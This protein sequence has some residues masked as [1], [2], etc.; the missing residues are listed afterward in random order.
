M[1]G[2]QGF[3]KRTARNGCATGAEV[4]LPE[5][6]GLKTGHYLCDNRALIG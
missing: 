1:D 6:A 3:A 2:R 5:P 4:G